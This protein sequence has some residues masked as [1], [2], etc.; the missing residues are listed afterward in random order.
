MDEIEVGG[1]LFPW[2]KLVVEVR[3]GYVEPELWGEAREDDDER[4]RV[5]TSGNGDDDTLSPR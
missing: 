2:T 3:D 1:G 4:R 5:R